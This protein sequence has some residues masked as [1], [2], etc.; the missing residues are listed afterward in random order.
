MSEVILR[1]SNFE[2]YFGD[3]DLFDKANLIIHKGDKITLLG[4][5]GVGKT[6][7]IRCIDSDDDYSGDIEL[8][9]GI[10][11]AFMEQEKSFENIPKTFSH[12]LEDKKNIILEKL[13]V[14]E[15]QFTDPTLFDDIPRYEKVMEEFGKLQSRSESNI[16]ELKIKEIL[17]ELGFEMEDY[18]KPIYSLSGG[19]KIKLRIAEVMSSNSDFII[20]DEPTNHLDFK[21]ID[22][23]EEKIRESNSTFLIISH[24]RTFVKYVSNKIVEVEDKKLETYDCTYSN[25]VIRRD[26][27]HEALKN[28]Y[29]SVERERRRLKKSEDEKRKWAHLVG[30]KKMKAVADN[31]KRRSENLGEHANPDDFTDTFELKFMDSTYMG[32][33]IFKGENLTKSFGNLDILKGIDFT[34]E[35]NDRV[36]FLGKNGC[37][38]STLLKML[39]QFDDD[40]GGGL[41][42]G[43]NVNIG[44][45]DQE[46]KNMDPKQSVM[47]FLWEAN[48]NLME[49]H[50]ISHLI[51]FGF[52][53]SRI[54]D[55]IE[56]LSGGEKTRIS[57]VKLLLNKYDVLLL[58]EPTNNLDIELIEALEKALKKYNGTV[59]FVSHDRRFINNVAEKIFM[60]KAGKLEVLNA[61][62]H[63]F[64]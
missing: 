41:K 57:L 45:L 33:N 6:S 62:D 38:K 22:W 10:S 15:E 31:L 60:I 14:Y 58:D 35:R 48:Q 64:G 53:F 39:A 29:T 20:L 40:H 43:N 2:K 46:F 23:L 8:S 28:K 11:I 50:V 32:T 12:Y 18:D 44:Y 61:N 30:S 59:V 24:D 16:D 34:I 63:R 27:R 5:N 56:K 21:S 55:K 25:Y 9:P 26:R 36:V 37:G 52:D 42:M 49:H 4:Q 7:F 54:N 13:S 19:Q 3:K 17:G 1:V 47:D 51:H